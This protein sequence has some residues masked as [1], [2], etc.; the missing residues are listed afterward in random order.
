MRLYKDVWKYLRSIPE[1][2]RNPATIP[3]LAVHV[4][5]IMCIGLIDQLVG[6]QSCSYR[7][8]KKCN[9]VFGC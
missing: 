8:K 5:L 6:R 2:S 7:R 1:D 3:A 4:K 9:H